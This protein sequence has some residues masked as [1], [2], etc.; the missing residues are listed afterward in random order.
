[1]I[2][3]SF[4]TTLATTWT[5]AKV[6]NMTKAIEMARVSAKGGFHLLWGLLASTVISAVG[7]IIIANL[8]GPD[9]YGLYAIALTAPNLISI[10]RDWGIT[11]ALIKYSAQYKAENNVAKIKSVFV[12]SLL[13]EVIL[14]LS[15]SVLSFVLSSF[16]ASNLNR[17]TMVNFIQAASFIILTGAIV[18][19][20]T[21]AFTGMEKMHLNSIMLIVQSIV[22][23]G[24]VIALVLLGFG[25]FG[26]VTGF[27]MAMLITAVTGFLLVWTVYKPLIQQTKCKLE[28]LSTVKTMLK[29]GLPLSIS[30]IVGGFLTQFLTYILAIFVTSNATIGNYSVAA[31]FIILI[32]FFAMPINTMMFPAFSKLDYNKDKDSLRIVF[33]YS[34]KYSAIV[35]VP[36]SALVITLAQPAIGTIFK[37]QYA[38]AP[39]FLALLSVSYLLSAFGSLS[40]NNL[41]AGQ[42]YTKFN[43]KMTLLGVAIGFPLGFVLISQLGVIGLIITTFSIS[44]P[45]LIIGLRFIK[46]QFGVSI[47]WLSSAKIL[48]SA[49]IASIP[50][51]IIVSTLALSNPILL[52]IG[53]IIFSTIFLVSTLLTRTLNAADMT[54][55][56]QIIQGLGPFQKPLLSLL[57]LVEK[58]MKIIQG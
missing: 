23:T 52:I 48:L 19:V 29:Y 28:I 55:L 25:T 56:R 38:E 21:A 43:L 1:V 44:L 18:N 3:T 24:I 5:A 8:L 32:N 35:V 45:G 36:V 53:V 10:F 9:N 26:A 4:L 16:L 40:E 12:S 58:F 50:T 39:L 6:K 57:I 31:N 33:Q 13:F 42:G 41:I 49:V 2:D 15:L 51:Y 27:T 46:K 14:G 17:P 22:K 34:V 11:S 7:S 30:T 37:N 47:D 20:A 54:N